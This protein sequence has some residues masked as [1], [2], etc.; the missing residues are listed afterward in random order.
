LVQF[1]EMKTANQT[2]RFR[3][4]IIRMVQTKCSF[5]FGL[6]RFVVLLLNWFRYEHPYII[7]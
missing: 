4:K 7:L 2:V 6:V 1:S 3:R 5:R